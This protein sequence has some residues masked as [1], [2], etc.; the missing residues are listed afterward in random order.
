MAE[1]SITKEDELRKVPL[2]SKLSKK[3][4]AEVAE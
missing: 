1:K 2:F 4:L 3:N